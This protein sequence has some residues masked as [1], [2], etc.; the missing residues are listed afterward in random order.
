MG[1]TT[2]VY[3]VGIISIEG[4]Q[5]PD[6]HARVSTHLDWIKK[7]SLAGFC[8]PT[9][10]VIAENEIDDVIITTNGKEKKIISIDVIIRMFIIFGILFYFARVYT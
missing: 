10:D 6:M 3:V 5:G 2:L 4:I 9:S 1:W 7:N 8:S